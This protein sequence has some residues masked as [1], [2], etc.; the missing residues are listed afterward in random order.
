MC[1]AEIA[2]G[3]P[4]P[5]WWKSAP[6]ISGSSDSDL[7]ATTITDLPL[8]RSTFATW[9]SAG[10][11]PCARVHDQ[12]HA[13]RLLDGLQRLLGHQALDALRDLDQP[14]RVDHDAG[15][16]PDTRVT[17]LAVAREARHVGDERVARARD[18]IEE[19]R[20]ADVGAPDQGDDG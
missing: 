6:A 16:R 3:A 10:T 12:Q 5:S 4:K 2:T 20:L 17:V 19:R 15:T 14:A 11:Q 13:V 8:R 9:M 7:F 18:R 1:E